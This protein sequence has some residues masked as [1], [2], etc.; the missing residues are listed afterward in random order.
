MPEILPFD[1]TDPRVVPR[2]PGDL[3]PG[4]RATF[5]LSVNIVGRCRGSSLLRDLNNSDA[6]A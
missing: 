1:A 4:E 2:P 3:L 6:A 5:S